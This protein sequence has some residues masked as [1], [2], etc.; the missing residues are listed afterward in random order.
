MRVKRILTVFIMGA[1]LTVAGVV[2]PGV[3]F[4]DTNDTVT[5]SE[6]ATA[7][8]QTDAKSDDL[9]AEPISSKTDADSA[10]VTTL[11]GS[12]TDIPKDPEEGIDLKGES[13]ITI[14]LPN[15]DE[16]KDAQRLSDGTVTYPAT[17]GSANAV[18][19]TNDGVQVLTTI[20]NSDAPT[21]YDYNVSVPEGGS[22]EKLDEGYAQIIDS[23][24]KTAFYISLPWAKD[25]NGSAVPTHF[26]VEGT[27]LIQ[28]VDHDSKSFKYPVVADPRF[29]Y[30]W[31]TY[32]IKFNSTETGY[33]SRAGAAAVGSL[34]NQ[35]AMVFFATIGGDWIADQAAQRG[36]CL[37]YRV[38]PW[39]VWA[40]GLW[41]E[42]C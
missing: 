16:A 31:G 15:A 1:T 12:T 23:T 28:V 3:A 36:M 42:Y 9:V 25:A 19:P 38:V 40:S 14:G 18:I 32:T 35:A 21:R 30:S 13:N 7:I 8:N 10:A 22:V 29:Y 6:I 11:N 26:E 34:V 27:K 24:G 4:A 17:D 33:I 39:Y 5:A 20:A 41:I 37:V 2:M